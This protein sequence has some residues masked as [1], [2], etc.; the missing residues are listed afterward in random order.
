MTTINKFLRAQLEAAHYRHTDSLRKTQSDE[1]ARMLITAACR[2]LISE[3]GDPGVQRDM[4]V[5]QRYG[6]A[7]PVHGANIKVQSKNNWIFLDTFG[8]KF[9]SYIVIPGR[10][11][12]YGIDERPSTYYEC[13]V[14]HE[15]SDYDEIYKAV[16]WKHT[17]RQTSVTS[18]AEFK[19]AIRK[20]NSLSKIEH[21][22]PWL[23]E[24]AALQSM[25]IAT[26]KL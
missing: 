6:M 9:I 4:L 3:W 7:A 2:R 5:C 22:Y 21:L 11:M 12:S 8:V 14:H 19:N 23:R 1:W 26:S 24:D 17:F 15:D 18:L 16:E 25:I 13:F 10:N 20:T